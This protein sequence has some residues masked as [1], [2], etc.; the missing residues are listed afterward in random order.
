MPM[1]GSRLKRNPPPQVQRNAETA[2][3]DMLAAIDVI[4]AGLRILHRDGLRDGRG[5]QVRFCSQLMSDLG[6]LGEVLRAL[7]S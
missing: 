4:T 1:H 2:A 5:F 7:S 3:G 6:A